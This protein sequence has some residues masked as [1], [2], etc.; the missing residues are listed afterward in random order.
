MVILMAVGIINPS[1]VDPSTKT[2]LIIQ[3]LKKV[4]PVGMAIEALCIAEY[5]GMDFAEGGKWRLSDLPRMGGL[6]LVRNGDQVID[7]LGLTTKTYEGVMRNMAIV[8]SINLL[9]SWVGLSCCGTK[10][11]TARDIPSTD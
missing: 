2:P 9:L 7:A 10:F 8:S 6:A 11:I 3:S 1:G 5:S 4:S